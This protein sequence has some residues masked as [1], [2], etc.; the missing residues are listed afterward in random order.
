MKDSLDT[1]PDLLVTFDPGV[2]YFAYAMW[3]I[4]QG[5][6]VACD[7]VSMP[8]L[9]APWPIWF[10]PGKY[11]VICEG[12]AMYKG[13]RNAEAVLGLARMTGAIVSRAY[14]G[15]GAVVLPHAWKAQIRRSA[16][17]NLV[18]KQM[19]ENERDIYAH[20]AA[21]LPLDK[22]RDITA[23]I[24]IGKWKFGTLKIIAGTRTRA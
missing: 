4:A 9:D 2:T 15:Q 16:I 20:V 18:L 1:G 7:W 24:G 23:A 17:H 6:L 19:D 8:A 3:D 12:Q 21:N 10:K 14:P 13:L 11:A 22:K 5:T